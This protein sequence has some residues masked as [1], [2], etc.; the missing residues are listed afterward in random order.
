MDQ[1]T[2]RVIGFGV[3][4]GI[5]DGVALC[6]M[7]H[8]AIRGHSLPKY[9]SSDHYPLY[10]FHQW[11]ANLRVLEVAEIKT[12]PYVPLSH[13]RHN[14]SIRNTSRTPFSTWTHSVP[15]CG[16]SSTQPNMGGRI[17]GWI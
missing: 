15:P 8:R 10:R 3:H 9:F 4:G 17:S 13:S 11:Q 12:I 1:F 6:R 7:F 2:R 14:L 16:P 5:V